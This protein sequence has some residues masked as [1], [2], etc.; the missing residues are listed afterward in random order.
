[1]QL[2]VLATLNLSSNSIQTVPSDAF[3]GLLSLRII[4]LSDNRIERTENKTHSI[5]EPCLNLEE[6]S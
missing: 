5:F 1:M 3:K 6:V 4:D 2:T